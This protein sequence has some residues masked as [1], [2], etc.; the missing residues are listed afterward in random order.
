MALI[1]ILLSSFSVTAFS[2]GKDKKEEIIKNLAIIKKMEGI[3]TL[4]KSYGTVLTGKEFNK[5]YPGLFLKLM[6]SDEIHYGLKY[7]DGICIDSK[8]FCPKGRCREGGLYFTDILRIQNYLG[9]DY[10]HFRTITIPDS[11]KIYLEKGSF[12]ATS[13]C[14]GEKSRTQDNNDLNTDIHELL[15]GKLNALLQKN[16]RLSFLDFEEA[17]LQNIEISNANLS[18]TDLQGV[19][20]D[21]TT[22]KN[23]DFQDANLKK[24]SFHY[25]SFEDTNFSYANLESANFRDTYLKKT[26]FSYANLKDANLRYAYFVMSKLPFAVFDYADLFHVELS[27]TDLQETSFWRA[28]LDGANL[29]CS[30]L[31]SSNFENANLKNAKLKAVNLQYSYLR[32]ADFEKADIADADISNADCQHAH[33]RGVDF[34][35]VNVDKTD[36]TN[37]NDANLKGAKNSDRSIGWVK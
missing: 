29:S 2:L 25:S 15:N 3:P 12:K 7:S 1:F 16:N 5:R 37:A 4:K 8:N 23:V 36:F 30:L 24:A 18:R 10:D 27:D 9:R 34:S 33:F 32:D 26:N 11:A 31:K 20:F 17:N 22:F 21:Q 35:E 13:I 14:L 6:R 19:Q 28:N